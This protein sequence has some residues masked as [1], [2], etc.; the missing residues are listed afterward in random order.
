MNP[1]ERVMTA[2]KRQVPDELP[3]SLSIGPTNAQRWLGKSD[4]RAVFQAHQMVGSIPEYGFPW[5]STTESN[6]IFIP[7][8]RHGWDEQ[9][10]TQVLHDDHAY[11]LKTRRITTPHGS[12]SSQERIDHPEYVMGQTQEPLIK[13]RQDYEIYL[14]Y[15]EEWLRVIQPAPLP[16]EIQAMHREIGDQGI[17]V[18]WR[19]LTFY[20]FFWVLRR[21]SDYLLDFYDAPGLMQQVLDITRKV[22]S[23]FLDYFNS[24]LCDIFIVNLSGA[25]TSIISPDFFKKWVFS[26]LLWF[27]EHIQPGKFLGFHTTGK[28]RAI[29]P[30]MLEANPDFILRFESPRFGGDISLS[31]AKRKYG[32]KVCLM[33]GYDPHFF[34]DYSLDNMC[35]EARRC[36]DEAAKDGGY[37][38]ATTDAIPE[39]AKWEDIRFVVQTAKEYGKY[40]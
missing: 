40:K 24:S 28:M 22:N 38:L 5:Y 37:I 23:A 25:S 4:W 33:G 10:L 11:Q 27:S 2:L 36:V 26:E 39:Q 1:K 16:E 34:V 8:W 21:V 12:L 31:E 35:D 7:H 18:M 13:T 14:E 30:V 6:P 29:L 15:I 9:V 19:T 17:F 32:D 3:I 20:S